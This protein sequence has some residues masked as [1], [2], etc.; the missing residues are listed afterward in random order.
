M[1]G[2]TKAVEIK[3]TTA[4]EVEMATVT[5][6]VVVFV[7]DDGTADGDGCGTTYTESTCT[8]TKVQAACPVMCGCLSD[9]TTVAVV[10]T[11]LA[12]ENAAG[13]KK[14]SGDNTGP[15]VGG[16]VAALLA[17]AG[18]AG[19]VYVTKKTKTNKVQPTQQPSRAVTPRRVQPFDAGAQDVEAQGTTAGT[20]AETEFTR[21]GA[22]QSKTDEIARTARFSQT[23]DAEFEATLPGA[24]DQARYLQPEAHIDAHAEPMET[25]PG[26]PSVLPTLPAQ[27]PTHA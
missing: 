4:V 13:G 26:A 16:V 1:N 23:L 2:V 18:V 9:T 19:A 17:V 6:S 11:L 22:L 25:D 3:E 5:I 15:I 8:D 27:L 24:P 14:S 20:V 10:T 21:N 7:C 12:A